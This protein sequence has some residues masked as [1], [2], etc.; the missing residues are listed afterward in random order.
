MNDGRIKKIAKTAIMLA[1]LTTSIPKLEIEGEVLDK[2]DIT[3]AITTLMVSLIEELGFDAEKEFEEALIKGGRLAGINP[4]LVSL[5]TKMVIGD[6]ALSN[7]SN[8]ANKLVAFY[9]SVEED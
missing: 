8:K 2:K 7:I 9:D 5:F 6:K 4:I 3:N 1:M